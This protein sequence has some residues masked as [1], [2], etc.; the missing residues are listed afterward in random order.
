MMVDIDQGGLRGEQS[1][2][3]T[4]T[5]ER[6]AIQY[7]NWIE[8]AQIIFARFEKVGIEDLPVGIQKR[9]SGGERPLVDYPTG[10]APAF[11]K[12]G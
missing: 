9:I 10:F 7:E 1:L 8:F 2:H 11:Q 4:Q 6:G 3:L 12:L 5:A